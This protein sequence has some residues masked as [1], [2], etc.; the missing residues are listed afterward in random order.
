VSFNANGIRAAARKGFFAWVAS[1]DPDFLCIQETKAQEHQVPPEA[2]LAD[3]YVATFVDAQRRGYSGVAVYARRTPDAIVR[4]TS[5]ADIDVEGRFLPIDCGGLSIVSVYFPSGTTGAARQAVK[6]AF[7]ERVLPLFAAMRREGRSIVV[8]GD[9]NIAH[10][11]IDVFDV[12]SA[13]GVTGFLPA[14][15]AWLDDLFGPIGWSDA[16]RVV[17]PE[18]RR[19]TWWSNHP[20]QFE[21]NNGWRIDYQAITPDLVPRVRSAAIERDRRFSDHAPLTIDYDI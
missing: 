2:L 3:R 11:D 1:R 4:G 7:L 6:T 20:G 9:F 15:R 18:P 13:R 19:F 14:E 21:R 10:R 8:C 12:R 17:D 16:M 5:I